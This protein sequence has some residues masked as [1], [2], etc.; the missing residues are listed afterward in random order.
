[1]AALR[2]L[3]EQSQAGGASKATCDD[4]KEEYKACLYDI[5]H[6]PYILG[7]DDGVCESARLQYNKKKCII[8]KSSPSS[9]E[10]AIIH[11]SHYVDKPN[12]YGNL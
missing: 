6:N 5:R 4:K 3:N 7:R 10:D 2:G 1:L 12:N 11:K 8:N 9:S